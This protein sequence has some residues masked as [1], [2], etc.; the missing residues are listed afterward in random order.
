MAQGNAEGVLRPLKMVKALRKQRVNMVQTAVRKSAE[1]DLLKY[2][3]N[4][5]LKVQI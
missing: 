3:L 4:I 1:P 2:C 5:P